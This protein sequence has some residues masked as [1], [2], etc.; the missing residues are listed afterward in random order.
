MSFILF[1]IISLK[2]ATFGAGLGRRA[3]VAIDDGPLPGNMTP[4]D[5]KKFVKDNFDPEGTEFDDWDPPDW[6]EE[7]PV[8]ETIKVKIYRN[9]FRKL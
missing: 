9:V 7:I 4:E 2:K 5:V 8:F 6:K 3:G 1:H